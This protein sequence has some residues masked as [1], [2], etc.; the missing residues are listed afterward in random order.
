M[1]HEWRIPSQAG[2]MS[3]KKESVMSESTSR[4]SEQPPQARPQR[5][6]YSDTFKHDTVRLVTHERYSV[7][8]AADAVGISSKTLRNWLNKARPAPEPCGDDASMQ[9]LQDEN[10][11]LRQQLKRAE[12]E[13]DILKKATAYFAKENT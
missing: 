2:K 11:R 6:F 8:A 9:Q 10:R 3:G 1:A 7:Q 13:R 4:T 12:M 5:R